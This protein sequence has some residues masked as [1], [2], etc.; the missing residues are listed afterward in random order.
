MHIHTHTARTVF[1]LKVFDFLENI[2]HLGYGNVSLVVGRG[3]MAV[4][5]GAFVAAHQTHTQQWQQQTV[6]SI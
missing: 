1:A 2:L 3:V 6:A 5:S 4:G